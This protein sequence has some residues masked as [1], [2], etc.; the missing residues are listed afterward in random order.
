MLVK[1]SVVSMSAQYARVR[2]ESVSERLEVRIGPERRSS[3][4]TGPA[5]SDR[6]SISAQARAAL[7][8]A[9]SLSAGESQALQGVITD[10]T[11]VDPQIRMIKRI[12]ELLTGVKIDTIELS[13]V[14]KR[15]RGQPGEPGPEAQ[16]QAQA[17]EPE[18]S[19]QYDREYAYHDFQY[20]SFE[21]EG[22]IVTTDGEHIKFAL[23]LSMRHEESVYSRTSVRMQNGKKVDPIVINLTGEAAQLADALFEFDLNGDGKTEMIPELRRG[24]GFLVF[25]RNGDGI[26]NDGTELFGHESGNGMDELAQLDSDGNGWL[27]ERDAAWTQLYVWTGGASGRESLTPLD[28]AGVGAI[29]LGSVDTQFQMKNSANRPVGEVARIGLYFRED[30]SVGSLQQIDLIV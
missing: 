6:V 21:A 3:G 20:M 1:D 22:T 13:K 28:K 27:D 29:Y 25:D 5:V 16:A 11:S 24:S 15:R 7:A 9:D 23:S 30:K 2:Q 26:A 17:V 10:E 14:L 12:I 8:E 18:W 19:V 4:P